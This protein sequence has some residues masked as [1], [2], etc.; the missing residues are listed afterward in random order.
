MSQDGDLRW[1]PPK[2]NPGKFQIPPYYPAARPPILEKPE[3][4]ARMEA[5]ALFFA[6]YY[7]QGTLQQAMAARELKNLN[8]KYHKQH[9]AWFQVLIIHEMYARCHVLAVRHLR[10]IFVIIIL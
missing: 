6:F 4:I 1:E 8:W 10:S 7:Q 9:Q 5:D 2:H 3:G